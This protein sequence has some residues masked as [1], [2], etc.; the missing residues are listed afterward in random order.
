MHDLK[1]KV[2]GITE[3]LRKNILKDHKPSETMNK[4][5]LVRLEILQEKYK[6][7]SK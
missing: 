6:D 2:L 7:I 1:T 3:E 5:N 4:Q